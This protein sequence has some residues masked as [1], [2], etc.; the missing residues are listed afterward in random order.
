MR[1]VP[2]FPE[3]LDHVIM[4]DGIGIILMMGSDNFWGENIV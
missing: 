4:A 1:C 2:N 3:T